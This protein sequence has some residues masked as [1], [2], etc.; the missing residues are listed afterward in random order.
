MN[1]FPTISKAPSFNNFRDV[2]SDESVTVAD[3]KNGYPFINVNFNFNPKY[4]SFSLRYVSQTDKETIE[5]FYE[6]NK[7]V[8]F[9]WLSEQNNITYEVVF[10]KK[11]HCELEAGEKEEWKI[12]LELIQAFV[13][14]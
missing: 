3:L 9:N 12:D 6:N 1:T 11:P 4:P 8:P 5:T 13:V 14:V 7:D 10:A 2:F